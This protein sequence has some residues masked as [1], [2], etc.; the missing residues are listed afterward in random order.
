M[1]AKP[2]ALPHS[3]GGSVKVYP[4]YGGRRGVLTYYL[5]LCQRCG[6]QRDN[7]GTDGTTISAIREWNRERRAAMAE[8][9]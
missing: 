6:F 3:C 7:Y 2:K 1:S 9:A 4:S 5:V 8:G